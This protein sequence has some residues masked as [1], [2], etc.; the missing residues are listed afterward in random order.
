MGK[1]MAQKISPLADEKVY[2]HLELLKEVN[3]WEWGEEKKKSFI[4]WYVFRSPEILEEQIAALSEKGYIKD[5][6]A[7]PLG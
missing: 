4:D 3:G 1:F 5:D 6:T 7:R 2:T